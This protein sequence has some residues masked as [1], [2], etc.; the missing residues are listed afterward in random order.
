MRVFT[1]AERRA[2]RARAHALHPI[3]MIGSAGLT[4]GVLKEIDLALKRHE[5]L[6]IR[7]LGEDRDSRE[8]ALERICGALDASPVQLIGKILV[9][10]RPKPEQPPPAIRKGPRPAKRDGRH[11]KREEK[12]ER[13][14][15]SKPRW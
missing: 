4:D 3:V 8:H 13:R 9:V 10:F 5:L 14:K 15:A 12:G 7:M 11:R 1:S 6:K 2:L